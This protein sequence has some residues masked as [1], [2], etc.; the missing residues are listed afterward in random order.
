[1]PESP[2]SKMPNTQ[3][4]VIRSGHGLAA[5]HPNAS[6][7][8][9][10]AAAIESA[11]RARPQRSDSQP[12]SHTPT[13]PRPAISAAHL[14]PSATASTALSPEATRTDT[15]KAAN[16]PRDTYSSHE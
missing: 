4:T 3:P 11:E 7:T 5:S 1:M 10:L 9:P 14:P 2:A 16:Q 12:P 6:E 13:A 8:T 15:R